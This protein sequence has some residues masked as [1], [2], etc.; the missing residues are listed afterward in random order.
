MTRRHSRGELEAPHSAHRRTDFAAE[1]APA[2]ADKGKALRSTGGAVTLRAGA[3]RAGRAVP[4]APLRS[5][6]AGTR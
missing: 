4:D 3:P 2:P 6:I 1:D 5:Q